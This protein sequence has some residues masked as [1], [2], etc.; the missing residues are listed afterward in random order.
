MVR[1]HCLAP[2]ENGAVVLRV[3]QSPSFVLAKDTLKMI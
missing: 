1:S 3:Q 2:P